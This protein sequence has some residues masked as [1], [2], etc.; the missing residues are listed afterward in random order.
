MLTFAF[1]ESNLFKSV[2]N[3]NLDTVIGYKEKGERHHFL[4]T[5]EMKK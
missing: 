4:D 1:V 5:Y 3:V 2:E